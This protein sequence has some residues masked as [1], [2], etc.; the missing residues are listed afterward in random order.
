M[1]G[2]FPL[3]DLWGMQ[4]AI[5]VLDWSMDPGL[6]EKTLQFESF[7]RTRS[8][9]TNITQAGA[10]ALGDVTGAYEKNRVWVSTVP[11]HRF[12]SAT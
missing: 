4:A 10:G 2:P 1:P 11:T 6:Y 3:E 12:W 5:A 7:R 9:V 8:A